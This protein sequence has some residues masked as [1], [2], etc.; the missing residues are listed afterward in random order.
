MLLFGAKR[1][2]LLARNL[3]HSLRIQT[4]ARRIPHGRRRRRELRSGLKTPERSPT[5]AKFLLRGRCPQ[6]IL[7]L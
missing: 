3:G 1:I 4:G 6:P 5:G 2:P 7:D